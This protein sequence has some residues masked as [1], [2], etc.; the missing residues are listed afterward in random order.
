MYAF[1]ITIICFAIIF[2]LSGGE[3]DLLGFRFYSVLTNSMV[4]KEDQKKKDNFYAHDVIVV[5]KTPYDAL[6]KGDVITYG[7]GDGEAYLTHRVVE[8]TNENNGEK[9][10][11][12]ITKGDANP[13][14]DP[15]VEASRVFGKVVLVIPKV[16]LVISFI[17]DNFWLCLVLVLSLFGSLYVLKNYYFTN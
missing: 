8:K 1:M 10:E 7:I 15:P 3:K 5:K 12:F 14:N 11:Y 4:P 16:G 13:S 2:T 17:R 9:G 6:N